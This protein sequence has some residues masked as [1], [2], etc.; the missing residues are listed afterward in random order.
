MFEL[1][2]PPPFMW[3]GKAENGDLFPRAQIV[4]QWMVENLQKWKG[5]GLL[6]E[7]TVEAFS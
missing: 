6:A 4:G 7:S 1:V 5:V 2:D 3:E